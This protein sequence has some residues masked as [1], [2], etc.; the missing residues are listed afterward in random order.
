MDTLIV[1]VIIAAVVILAL[2]V[3]AYFRS[4][5]TV[6]KDSYNQARRQGLARQAAEGQ[7]PFGAPWEQTFGS[8][9]FMV[10]EQIVTAGIGLTPEVFNQKVSADG[11]K[12]FRLLGYTGFN[13]KSAVN[14]LDRG[15]HILTIA[16]TRSGKGVSAVIPNLIT[17]TGS[18]VVNDVK[19]ENYAV[20]SEWRRRLGH[21]VLRFAPFEGETDFWNPFDLIEEDE[22]AWE[23]VRTFAELLLPERT[24]N[25]EFWNSEARNLLA[26]AILHMHTTLPEEERTMWNLRHLLTQEEEEFNLLLTTMA[27]SDQA[28]VQRAATTFLR[29]DVKVREGIMST[30]N[31]HMGI[32]DSPRLKHMMSKNSYRLPRMLFEPITVYFSVPPGKLET[33]APV[34]RL[35]MGMLVKHFSSYSGKCDYPVL[36][37]LD[38][39]PALGRMKVVEEGMT[40]LAGYGINFWLFAQDLKQLAA[41]YGDK[42][43]SIIANS[44]VKQFFGVADYETA[45]LVSYMCGSTTIPNISYSGEGGLTLKAA[46]LSTS[47]GERPLV[48]PN[49]VMSMEEG[50]QLLFHQGQ[51]V[52]GAAK[53]NYLNDAMFKD[54]E[55]QPLYD[56]N[57]FHR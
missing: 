34:I 36:F 19:G 5:G 3:P 41:T 55:G 28:M 51:Q 13:G 52:V 25:E 42:A 26:G 57:P 20:T 37:M 16:P 1:L 10:P 9:Y 47:T 8:A 24:Q 11:P 35:F 43:Q 33:Y 53:V 21:R 22:D 18:M 39:F 12:T 50:A 46:N 40:Y 31:S 2:I 23:D 4:L 56:P 38:E 45:Q 14:L 27:T 17:Y 32:W 48:T 44:S 15:G 49:E 29:A 30:L 6:Y 7:K 54:T